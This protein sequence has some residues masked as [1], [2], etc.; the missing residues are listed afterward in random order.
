MWGILSSI[1]SN[2]VGRKASDEFSDEE[3]LGTTETDASLDLLI[4]NVYSED[5]K[6]AKVAPIPVPS[7][8]LLTRTCCGKVTSLFH[9]DGV[10]D[11]QYFFDRKNAPGEG[12]DVGRTV[13]YHAVRSSEDNA[14]KVTRILHVHE[15]Q[16]TEEEEVTES[17]DPV[18]EEP[19]QSEM[20][21]MGMANKRTI[22][23]KVVNVAN[24]DVIVRDTLQRTDTHTPQCRETIFSLN[25]IS[26]EF[27]PL[28]GD[29]LS[30]DCFVEVSDETVDGS[31]QVVEVLSIKPARARMAEGVVTYW[32]RKNGRGNVNNEIFIKREVCE[33]GYIPKEKDE[34]K[35]EIIECDMDIDDMRFSWRAISVSPVHLNEQYEEKIRE[36]QRVFHRIDPELLKNK[37][38]LVVMENTNFG[39][40]PSDGNFKIE[41]VVTNAGE[42]RKYIS[43]YYIDTEPSNLNLVSPK[44]GG[45][46]IEPK[47]SV[48]F[49]FIY[50]HK[51]CSYFN[52]VFVIESGDFLIGRLIQWEV[53]NRTILSSSETASNAVDENCYKRSRHEMALNVLHLQE[54][55]SKFV[56]PPK[57]RRTGFQKKN[58]PKYHLPESFGKIMAAGCDGMFVKRD[59]SKAL[60]ENYPELGQNLSPANHKKKFHNLLY[61]A[62]MDANFDMD[63]YS[64]N[65]VS[66]MRRG[67]AGEYL[68]LEVAALSEGRLSLLPGD[69]VFATNS[70][71]SAGASFK[72]RITKVLA[73]E[74]W[75][76]FNRDFVSLYNSE[77]YDVA[78]CPSRGSFA[79]CHHAVEICEINQAYMW[80]FPKSVSSKPPQ[81]VFE[82]DDDL[83][84]TGITLDLSNNNEESAKEKN[85][86]SGMCNK[87]L[88]WFNKRLNH[89]QKEAVRNIL[90]GEARP[91]PYIIFGPPGTGKTMTLVE[92]ILQIYSLMADSRILIAT[93]SNSAANLIAERLL[94]SKLLQPGDLTRLVAHHLV[95]EGKIP[96]RLLPYS[97][98]VELDSSDDEPILTGTKR[99]NNDLIMR[100]RVIIGTC[101]ALGQMMSLSLSRGHFTHIVVDEAGQASEPEILIPLGF[102][103]HETGQIVLAGD[104]LQLGPVV[105]SSLAADFG[106]SKSLLARLISRFPYVRDSSGFP[107][108]GGYDPRLVTRL[109]VNYRSLPDILELPSSLFYDSDLEPWVQED[110]SYEA[111]VMVR[112]TTALNFPNS[113]VV[114]Q[115]IKGD[116]V[117]EPDNPS[118]W[119]FQECFQVVMLVQE[120]LAADIKREDIGVI[121]PYQKQAMKIR[122]H[123]EKLDSS[124]SVDPSET[125]KLKVGSVEEFQGQEKMVVIISTVRSVG[126][127]HIDRIGRNS[128]RQLLGFV[129]SPERLNVA[130]SRA[131]A[132]LVIC[133]DPEVLCIDHYWRS[134]VKYCVEKKSYLGVALPKHFLE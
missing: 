115:G 85:S 125:L 32:H 25:K 1:I 96:P 37:G 75:I 5:E 50:N 3:D 112:A 100:H 31:G 105:P 123:L 51:F 94:D 133:G 57:P 47:E 104:P 126:S 24:R 10:I 70:Y 93:P 124:K 134:V 68:A 35:M 79:K 55:L 82:E 91:L 30:M 95:L 129:N 121:T 49:S 46:F 22:V 58:I 117:R 86:K 41:I 52:E 34:V 43:K 89:R 27:V 39:A 64:K 9:S 114:F 118:F 4:N 131:R 98:T 28:R 60:K 2:V 103:A 108:T 71:S 120:L 59:V 76:L 53:V 36:P 45:I 116:T 61:I 65:R 13:T 21:L 111:K 40:L 102:L 122:F 56:P 63:R 8:V 48:I 26:S 23:G 87:K 42:S 106:L 18:I 69:T 99:L 6:K 130:I 20:G 12:L 83:F 110:D 62:E 92:T 88:N 84:L 113:A 80:L 127:D 19:K 101:V 81:I 109:S 77:D 29:I 15:E 132:L 119:N 97:A 54:N 38:S 107:D 7:N 11:G 90:Q 17:I 78:F 128:V 33:P 73:K 14:W 72:G 67:A 16:W 44:K 66:F 74:V